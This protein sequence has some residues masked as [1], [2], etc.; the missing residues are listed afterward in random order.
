MCLS[1]AFFQTFVGVI[2]LLAFFR[3]YISVS[4]GPTNAP[5]APN[6][7]HML[8][9]ESA[10]IDRAFREIDDHH[11]HHQQHHSHHS[12]HND[13]HNDHHL[14]DAPRRDHHS[15]SS[16]QDDRYWAAELGHEST[17]NPTSSASSAPTSSASSAPTTVPPKPRHQFETLQTPTGVIDHSKTA[18]HNNDKPNKPKT[19]QVEEAQSS[20]P[21]PVTPRDITYY[22]EGFNMKCNQDQVDLHYG[23][24]PPHTM[25][26]NKYEIS[27]PRTVNPWHFWA[28]N[29]GYCSETVLLQAGLAAGQFLSQYNIRKFCGSG[30][31]QAGGHDFCA[32]KLNTSNYNAQMGLEVPN[33]GTSGPNKFAN[34]GFCAAQQRI[35]LSVYDGAKSPSGWEGY[36]HYMSW[37]KGEFLKGRP[38]GLGMLISTTTLSMSRALVPIISRSPMS[39]MTMTR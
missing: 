25:P 26:K 34:V 4:L 11:H 39:I 9:S 20:T 10:L 18:R 24:N 13:H 19:W 28:A 17:S 22:G 2:L 16:M 38:V 1:P 36:R 23:V 29:K 6:H 37:I 5:V 27:L 21:P 8:E 35:D 14:L 12:H 15:R 3:G 33:T 7:M 31:G 30:Y 32:K